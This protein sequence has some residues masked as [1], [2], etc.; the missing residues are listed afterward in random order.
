MAE[1]VVDALEVV[2]VEAEDA[3]RL[4]A[5]PVRAGP[6]PFARRRQARFRRSVRAS[7]WARCRIFSSASR[8][9]VMSSKGRD[10]ARS[11]V[12]R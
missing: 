2:E 3:D 12:G 9:S 5:P 6:L 1:R 4:G 7:W 11:G 10:E 8:R